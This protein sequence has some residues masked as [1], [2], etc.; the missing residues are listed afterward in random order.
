MKIT[1]TYSQIIISGGLIHDG[2]RPDANLLLTKDKNRKTLDL[3]CFPLYSIL[4]ALNNPVIHYFSL[5]IEG[6]ELPVLEVRNT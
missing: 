4:L 6:A 3:Q 2:N 5:D 1:R